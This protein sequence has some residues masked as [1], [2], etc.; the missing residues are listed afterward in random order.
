V[1]THNEKDRQRHGVWRNKNVREG[2]RERRGRE[3]RGEWG[4]ER[5]KGRETGME[6]R[7]RL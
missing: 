7:Q 6:S 5:K 3:E 1:S 4:R 2:E